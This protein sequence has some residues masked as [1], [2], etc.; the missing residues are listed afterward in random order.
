MKNDF[1]LDF[2]LRLLNYRHPE[3]NI[4]F[5]KKFFYF[6]QSFFILFPHVPTPMKLIGVQFY[7]GCSQ[8]NMIY[9]DFERNHG[10][11]NHFWE[12]VQGR[13]LVD[14]LIGKDG[15]GQRTGWGNSTHS[16]QRKSE[17]THDDMLQV[18][19]NAKN[20]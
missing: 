5:Y 9:I 3:E 18:T 2:A 11:K 7:I 17:E 12:G 19:D 13:N 6:W 8:Q 20:S 14:V 16:K 15:H 4:I 10:N 1:S